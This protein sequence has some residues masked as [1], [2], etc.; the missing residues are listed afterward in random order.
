MKSLVMF[1]ASEMIQYMHIYLIYTASLVDLLRSYG[2]HAIIITF[3]CARYSKYR[4]ELLD[5]CS[6]DFAIAVEYMVV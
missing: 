4:S 1:N 2:L 3:K 5:S 6:L